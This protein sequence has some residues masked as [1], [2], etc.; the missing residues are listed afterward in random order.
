MLGYYKKSCSGVS[1][2]DIKFECIIKSHDYVKN[3]T[4]TFTCPECNKTLIKILDHYKR[5]ET[6]EHYR[7]AQEFVD[8]LINLSGCTEKY[9]LF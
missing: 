5:L 9:Q 2:N 8:G 3:I 1:H 7:D 4:D 6:D